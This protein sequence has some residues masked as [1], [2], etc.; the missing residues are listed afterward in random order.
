MNKSVAWVV[1]LC[2]LVAVA[3]AAFFLLVMALPLS[4]ATW[5]GPEYA[6]TTVQPF[7]IGPN[8]TLLII[9]QS[10]VQ[11]CANP[12]FIYVQVQRTPAPT[13]PT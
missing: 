10:I 11:I 2:T 13:N 5:Y 9:F 7:E 3:S 6:V 1:S 8:L 12:L 4:A